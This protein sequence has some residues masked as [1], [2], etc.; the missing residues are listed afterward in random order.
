MAHR[1][2][3]RFGA[4]ATILLVVAALAILLEVGRTAG[5][6]A[7]FAAWAVVAALE[8]L[9]GRRAAAR[10]AGTERSDGG[11]EQP[12]AGA[13]P[14]VPELEPAAPGQEPQPLAVSPFDE[15]TSDGFAGAVLSAAPPRGEE[16]RR[17]EGRTG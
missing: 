1:L 17:E 11:D 12:V 14:F 3:S 16:S 13:E 15:T 9:A 10:R 2:S 6:V 5:V 4:E 7:V 8:L